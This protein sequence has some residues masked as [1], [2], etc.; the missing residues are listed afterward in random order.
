MAFVLLLRMLYN[1][2]TPYYHEKLLE[3]S[4]RTPNILKNVNF[5][6]VMFHILTVSFWQLRLKLAICKWRLW[7][8]RAYSTILIASSLHCMNQVGTRYEITE[9]KKLLSFQSFLNPNRC[10][11]DTILRTLQNCYLIFPWCF[12]VRAW[13]LLLKNYSYQ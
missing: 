8:D 3:A 7:L 1:V 6:S 2:H 12:I 4:R 11:R 9:F 5:S 13:E 10:T